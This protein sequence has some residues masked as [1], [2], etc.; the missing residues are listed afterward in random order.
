VILARDAFAVPY[1]SEF[2]NVRS[3]DGLLDQVSKETGGRIIE[4]AA[5]ASADIFRHDQSP[6]LHMQPIWYWLVILAAALLLLDVAT[7]RIAIEPEAIAGKLRDGWA[8]LRGK[9]KLTAESQQYIERLRSRKAAVGAQ[10]EQGK[11]A[12]RF[13]APADVQPVEVS[14]APP[15][16]RPPPRPVERPRLGAEQEQEALDFATRLMRAKQKAREQIEGKNEGNG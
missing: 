10:L 13:E 4:E 11:A 7:R 8:R 1:S 12:K 9:G 5:L 15:A 6:T 14:T 16:S 3:N 2:S